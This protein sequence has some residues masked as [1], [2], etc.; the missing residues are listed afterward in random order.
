MTDPR[1][2][3]LMLTILTF[4]PLSIPQTF[5]VCYSIHNLSLYRGGG[6]ETS[7]EEETQGQQE[8]AAAAE[9]HQSPTM[10]KGERS[11]SK[12]KHSAKKSKRSKPSNAE[13][14]SEKLPAAHHLLGS[15]RPELLDGAYGSL[16]GKGKLENLKLSE[17][18]TMRFAG[19]TTRVCA[20]GQIV[21]MRMNVRSAFM[22]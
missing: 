22:F 16:C 8:V 3:G 20:R 21:S 18:L 5:P 12:K 7:S 19:S 11:L 13:D 1:E 6:S 2:V 15:E 14:D 9:Q 17:S 4:L 10:G